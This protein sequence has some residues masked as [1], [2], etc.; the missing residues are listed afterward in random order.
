MKSREF[1]PWITGLALAFHLI[2]KFNNQDLNLPVDL[3]LFNLLIFASALIAINAPKVNNKL[4]NSLIGTAIFTWGLGSLVSA[5]SNFEIINF[6]FAIADICYVLFY[7]FLLLGLIIANSS[8]LKLSA[9]DLIDTFIVSLGCASILAAF[10]INPLLSSTE[11]KSVELYLRIFYIC[12]D[13]LLLIFTI[14][15]AINYRM[16]LRTILISFGLFIFAIS[17]LYF[18]WLNINNSY[19]FASLSDDGWLLGIFLIALGTKSIDLGTKSQPKAL[20][21]F[22]NLALIAGATLL[23]LAALKPNYLPEFVLIPSFLTIAFAFIRM[24][25]AIQEAKEASSE[26]LLARTDELTGLANRR[27]FL[28]SLSETDSGFLMLIDLNDFKEINDN[29]GHDV[30]DQVLKQ[31]AQRF[32]RV[33]D[34]NTTTTIARLGGDEFGVVTKSDEETAD[35]L[36]QAL[37]STLSYPVVIKTVPFQVGASVGVTHFLAD[38]ESSERLRKA[39][40][41]MYRAKNQAKNQVSNRL[42]GNKNAFS[43]WEKFEEKIFEKEQ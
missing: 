20:A 39:D 26:R 16:Q 18:L 40:Q 36:V 24:S 43:H 9:I 15:I 3:Y 38:Q 22:A 14:L 32:N 13:S 17:D 5:L 4:A 29:F 7:P 10:L 19:Q 30:G 23:G 6:D 11:I 12:A 34:S 2:F 31:V 27:Y 25:L 21:Y 8:K 41:A 28:K 35:E 37:L 1:L 42:V 33:I